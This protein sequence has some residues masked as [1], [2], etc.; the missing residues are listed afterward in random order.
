M[1]TNFRLTFQFVALAAAT[2]I[3]AGCKPNEA[4]SAGPPEVEVVAV[5]QKDVP[6]YR[7]WVGTLEA[8]V[9]ATIK[10]EITGYLVRRE[11]TEGRLVTKGQLLFQID[12]RTYK[13]A[14]DQAEAKATK[15]AEDVAR[16][17]PLAKAHAIPQMQLDNAIQANIAA[18]AA[19]EQARLNYQFCKITSPVDGLA[20]LAQVQVGNL[21][22]PSTEKLTTVAK[23][24]PIRANFSVSQEL[25]EQMQERRLA[26]GKATSR[27]GEGPELELTLASG[28][29]YPLKGHVRF[30]NN[31]VDERTGTVT[32]VGEFPNPQLLLVPGMFVRVRALI[33]TDK[34]ALVVPQRAVTD[35]QD[36]YLIAVV[37]ADNKVTIGPVEV[38]ER[39]GQE[40]VIK[41][42]LKAGD[43]VVAEGIQ[44]VRNGIVVK[45]APFAAKTTTATP[46]ETKK[47]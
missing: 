30:A 42:N 25:M 47:P 40:W 11:Y 28:A 37:D 12:D 6:I 18:V 32:V 43:K 7:D 38:G 36:R 46:D 22:S 26:K 14:L 21:V 8:E 41:G 9:N 2:L 17:T 33:D 20:G 19:A 24:N 16:D 27:S 5:A 44:K 35:M 23:V 13:T 4:G 10:A 31:Q 1:N 15:T 3:V 29:I 45:P 34:N 39:V